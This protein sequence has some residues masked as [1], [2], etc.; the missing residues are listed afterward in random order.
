TAPSELPVAG[1]HASVPFF[2]QR[3][4]L[5]VVHTSIWPDASGGLANVIA[6]DRPGLTLPANPMVDSFKNSRRVGSID[7]FF[8]KKARWLGRE[9]SIA[10]QGIWQNRASDSLLSGRTAVLYE[11]SG[12]GSGWKR[13]SLT[14]LLPCETAERSI[15][16][17]ACDASSASYC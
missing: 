4:F 12:A 8:T 6:D 10:M 17:R 2:W 1:F 3:S 5:L 9:Y 16:V 11:A 14:S 15:S 7:I 13:S